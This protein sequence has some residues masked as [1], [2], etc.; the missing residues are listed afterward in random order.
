MIA[1]VISVSWLPG[2]TI[3]VPIGRGVPIRIIAIA[4]VVAVIIVRVVTVRISVVRETKPAEKDK[5]VTVTE[6]SA[7][8]PITAPAV[9]IPAI[10]SSLTECSCA[11]GH[12]E[13]PSRGRPP[14]VPAAAASAAW[15][16]HRQWHGQ[17]YRRQSA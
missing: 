7:V 11:A 10:E 8:P 12:R 15:I 13:C 9:A 4:I 17:R 3:I 1:I 14:E 6:V 2:V 16:G 5:A